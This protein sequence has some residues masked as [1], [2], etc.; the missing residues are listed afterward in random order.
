MSRADPARALA[1]AEKVFAVLDE[2]A[3]SATYKYAVMLAL[4]DLCFEKTTQRGA[5][6]DT[7]TTREVAEKVLELYW[8]QC[9]PY[10]GDAFLKQGSGGQAEIVKRIIDFRREHAESESLRRCAFAAPREF[11][12]LVCFIEWKLIEMPLP[13]LQVIGTAEDRFLYDYGWTQEV[14]QGEVSAYQRGAPGS[15]DNRLLLRPDV[16]AALISL[17]TLLRPFIQREWL[18]LVEQFNRGWIP[19]ARLEQFLFDRDRAALDR[20]RAPLVKLQQRRCFYCGGPLN[21]AVDVD[22]FVPWARY[23]ND[24]I[25]NLVASHGGCNNQKRDFL[26]AGKHVE[27]WLERRERKHDAL[28]AIASA[29]DW[30]PPAARSR[31][32]ALALYELLPDDARVWRR[33]RDFARYA[34]ERRSI[35]G[36][37]RAS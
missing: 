28:L 7:L 3:F 24:A 22:H 36:M 6:P 30:E 35:L 18:R 26:T 27:T 11:E 12:R 9:V 10:Q 5:P 34:D 1:V 29:A 8:P 13:R 32:V 33:G 21:S 15:F 25:D 14:R 19:Q 23:P 16:G 37:L 2:G 4:L 31:S 17:N 20:I